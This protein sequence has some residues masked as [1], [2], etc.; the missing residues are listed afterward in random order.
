MI[1]D[2]FY[3]FFYSSALL[4]Y[5]IGINRATILCENPDNMVLQFIKML[6][7]VCCTAVITYALVTK[8]LIKCNLAELF[9][10][11]AIVLFCCISVF[12][13]AIIRLT[14]KKNTA[15]FAVS[16]MI[17]LLAVNESSS[18]LQCFIICI[19]STVT[20]FAV[21]PFLFAIRKRIEIAYPS[22]YFKNSS[23]IFISIGVIMIIL[24][25]Y[26]ASWLNPGV[27]R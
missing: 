5:G 16:F 22:R 13:E 27:F 3:Y 19:L 4:I 18:L 6:I 15:D 14:A 25:A 10:F 20:F 12:L 23:L 1:S 11:I 24:A 8:I 21:I 2:F 17:I 26:G 7:S 9:P